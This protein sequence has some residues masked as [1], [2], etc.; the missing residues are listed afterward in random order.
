MGCSLLGGEFYFLFFVMIFLFLNLIYY[1]FDSFLTLLDFF[2][3]AFL[4]LVNRSPE[5]DVFIEFAL[6]VFQTEPM[7]EVLTIILFILLR[8]RL[9]I[10]SAIRAVLLQ[11]GMRQSKSG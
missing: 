8:H 10:W 2:E 5:I 7:G 11:I 3:R 4:L 1:L 9:G 6:M